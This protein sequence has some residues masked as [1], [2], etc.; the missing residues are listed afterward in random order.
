MTFPEFIE[1]LVGEGRSDALNDPHFQTYD[2]QCK[3][4]FVDYD[5]IV[6]LE[7]GDQDQA[8][9]IK[10]FMNPNTGADQN[11][12]VNEGKDKD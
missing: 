12:R 11:F 10:R 9:F 2:H 6:K 3:L 8:T 4:C 5:F 7:T 1:Y